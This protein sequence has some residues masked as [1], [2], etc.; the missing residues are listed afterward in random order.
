M[1][2]TKTNAAMLA[3]LALGA[4]CSA[5]SDPSDPS[6][7]SGERLTN[8]PSQTFDGNSGSSETFTSQ[9]VLD[10]TN[11]FFQPLG[12]NGRACANCH[13]ADQGWTITPS[14]VQAL[15]DASEGT[16]VLFKPHDAA[17]SP[18]ADVSTVE[19]RRE[20]YKL[21]LSRAVVRIGIAMPNALTSEF[22]LE[23]VDDPYG[24]ASATQLSL[25]RRPLPTANLSFAATVS[26]DARLT[27]PAKTIFEDLVEQANRANKGHGQATTDLPLD[28]RVAIAT[29][30]TTTFT[31]R[32]SVSV[33]GPLDKDGALGGAANLA[34]RTFALADMYAAWSTTADENERD[35]A[36]AAIA[37]GAKIFAEPRLRRADGSMASCASCHDANNVGSSTVTA[38]TFDIGISD[39]SRRSRDVPLYTFK[40]KATGETRRLTDPGRGLITGKWADLGRFKAPMLRDLA[41]RAP[42]FHDGS[43]RTIEEVVEHYEQRFGADLGGSERD[44]LVAF[45][46]AL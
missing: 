22:D 39:E 6:S 20:A 2:V 34:S 13:Q 24:W 43:A 37:R 44:D 38:A 16:D 30:E 14:Y 33:A 42:Y 23:A 36:R 26:W 9:P 27:L 29:F 28:V 40:N 7:T 1:R 21:I 46:E 45:L 18:K 15:F 4:G 5:V 8:A 19:A 32:R 11:A 31:A 25:Y 12:A 17:T 10:V 41:A 35:R 3:M